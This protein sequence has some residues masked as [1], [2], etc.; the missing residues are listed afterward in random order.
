MRLSV[1]RHLLAGVALLGALT[2]GA[3]TAFLASGASGPRVVTLVGNEQKVV[4]IKGSDGR[5]GLTIAG[6][7]PNSITIVANRTI[8]NMRTDC[9]VG[10]MSTT[11][12][13]GP[14]TKGETV[15]ETIDARLG[16]GGDGLSFSDS[17][18]ED[19]K[20]VRLIARGAAGGD[21]LKGSDFDDEFDGGGGDDRLRGRPGADDLD[22][23]TGKDSCKGGPGHDQIRRCE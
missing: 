5:D 15:G 6:A 1:N 23:G 18:S 17:F 16:E 13:C 20:A 4:T 21:A 9:D 10:P 12:F 19:S 3:A 8:S 22:G 7:A 2:A 14:D 11:A